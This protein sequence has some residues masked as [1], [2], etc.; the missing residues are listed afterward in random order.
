MTKNSMF[1]LDK[2]LEQD[3]ISLGSLELCQV[4]L[5][6]DQQYPW[7]IL[8]P[9]IEGVSEIYQLST[10]QQLALMHESNQVLQLMA[11]EF[12][13]DKMNVAAL[14]NVVSQLHLHHIVRYKGDKAWPAPVWGKNPVELYSESD[15]LIMVERL[16]K[17][18]KKIKG[19]YSSP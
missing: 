9:K 7:I 15:L 6:N 12:N 3:T 4:L 19:F 18:L 17:L 14:G 8:V 13:A 1:K 5:M 16:Q 11:Q 10:E 2:Q